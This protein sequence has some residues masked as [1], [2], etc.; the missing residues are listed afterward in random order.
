M[1]T[2][3]P[4]AQTAVNEWPG[5]LV[6]SSYEI[7]SYVMTMVDFPLRA[8]KG[9]PVALAYEIYN[10]GRGRCSW[11]Q[12]AMLEAVRPGKYWNYHP[13]GRI[14]VDDEFVTHWQED[15]SRRHSYLLPKVNYEIV[16]QA[17]D[18]LLDGK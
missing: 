2:G 16:R 14:T 8:Q 1:G 6:F 18:D 3:L 7:G 4:D 5:E 13:F 15:D 10:H 9:D 17:I 12:T 11:D